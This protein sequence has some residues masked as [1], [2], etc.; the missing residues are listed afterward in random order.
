MQ[1]L[2]LWTTHNNNTGLEGALVSIEVA[3]DDCFN[4]IFDCSIR[5]CSLIGQ[6]TAVFHWPFIANGTSDVNNE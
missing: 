3:I 1:I 2:K 4:G 5:I 6:G